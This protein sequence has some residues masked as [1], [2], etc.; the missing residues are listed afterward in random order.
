MNKRFRC[1]LKESL[2]TT[3]CTRQSKELDR[4][5]SASHHL[6]IVFKINS[7][8]SW[9]NW[10]GFVAIDFVSDIKFEKRDSASVE[11]ALP[12]N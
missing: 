11:V 5:I 1:P 12:R 10:P 6:S 2:T 8:F 7:W 9:L 4:I 3:T